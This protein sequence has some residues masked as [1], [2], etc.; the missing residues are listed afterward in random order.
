MT[1]KVTATHP[2]SQLANG[3]GRALPCPVSMSKKKVMICYGAVL[4]C[5]LAKP[6]VVTE[7]IVS[8]TQ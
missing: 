2:E 8:Y 6:R 7:V 5:L 4:S 3:M 1:L